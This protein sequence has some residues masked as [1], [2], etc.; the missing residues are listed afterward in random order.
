M[1][2]EDT[3]PV[4]FHKRV[5][6]TPKYIELVKGDLQDFTDPTLTQF[7]KHQMLIV[8]K[9]FRGQN[10]RHFKKF[11]DPEQAR[12]NPPPKLRNREQSSINRTAKAKQPYNHNSDAKCFY[13]D[14]T[15]TLGVTSL[16]RKRLQMRIV[17]CWNSSPNLSQRILNYSIGTRYARSFWRELTHVREVN[18][19]KTRLE[20]V[21]EESN[22][23]HKES[24]R[25]IEAQARH[26]EE[27]RK[28]IE[29]LSRTLR[30]P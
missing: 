24:A 17:K 3:F 15:R 22:R 19:L 25:L 29:E 5:D 18:E 11:D 7:V 21:E 23:K 13:N 6:V 26:M 12:A 27:M 10:H 28:M 14:N 16:F 2:M 8:W 1:L 30:G 4:S 20:V 9:E